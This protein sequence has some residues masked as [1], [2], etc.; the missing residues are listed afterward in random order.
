MACL[1]TLNMKVTN[2]YDMA[3]CAVLFLAKMFGR[4]FLPPSLG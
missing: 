2:F 1:L 4:K 3:S